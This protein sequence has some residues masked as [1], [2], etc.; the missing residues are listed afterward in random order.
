MGRQRMLQAMLGVLGWVLLD[1]SLVQAAVITEVNS[2]TLLPIAS[3]YTISIKDPANNT[4]ITGTWLPTRNQTVKIVLNISGFPQGPLPITLASTSNYKGECTNFGSPS[5]ANYLSNDFEVDSAN[6]DLLISR[7]CGGQAVIS[8]SGHTFLVPQNSDF[9]AQTDHIPD[10]YEQQICVTNATCLNDG[11]DNELL[12]ANL[13]RGDGF[14][15]IDEYRGFMVSGVHVRTKTTQKDVFE[16]LV[17][18]QCS[19]V[20]GTTLPTGGLTDSLI[21]KSSGTRLIYPVDGT[22]LFN[23]VLNLGGS[24]APIADRLLGYQEGG[25]NPQ[26]TT[27]WVDNFAG[28][29]NGAITYKTGITD[30]AVTDRQ[31]N[32]NAISQIGI[33]R[34]IRIIECVD[35]SVFSP[36]GF[37]LFPPGIQ[38]GN[39]DQDTNSIIYTQR[40][41]HDYE[42]VLSTAGSR[43]VVSKYKTCALAIPPP[44]ACVFYQTYT[45]SATSTTPTTAT[46]KYPA[47]GSG[48]SCPANSTNANCLPIDRNFIVSKYIQWVLAME[49][50]HSVALIPEIQIAQYGPH[51]APGSGDNLDQRIVVK[52]GKTGVIYS[53]P[54]AFGSKSNDCFQLKTPA[55]A[56]AS[57]CQ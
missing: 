50:G 42:R 38:V 26:N 32:Q 27:E 48:A 29:V 44:S 2:G 43:G 16:I 17:N 7:D 34:A 47:P 24:A 9:N 33:H 46:N 13:N 41:W 6:S 55:G 1:G 31:V 15:A 21:G 40:I 57:S 36:M 39:P 4:D 45:H 54:F 30:P 22:P 52:D 35:N 37:A 20:S 11:D 18:Q 51:F 10:L 23:N 12:G 28:L 25:I 56:Q 5:D 3:T 53:I 49:K 14:A 8:V 19:K